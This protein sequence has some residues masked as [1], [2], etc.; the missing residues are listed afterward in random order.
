MVSV[1]NTEEL[2]NTWQRLKKVIS[3]DY[4]SD[5]VNDCIKEIEE[6]RYLLNRAN[7]VYGETDEIM[8][9]SKM[10]HQITVKADGKKQ[11][12]I[13]NMYSGYFNGSAGEAPAKAFTKARINPEDLNKLNPPKANNA[14]K[15]VIGSIT[16]TTTDPTNGCYQWVGGEGKEA[17]IFLFAWLFVAN[18][19]FSQSNNKNIEE[20][21]KS[22]TKN[23]VN[24]SSFD[25]IAHSEEKEYCIYPIPTQPEITFCK[26]TR[27]NPGPPYLYDK[28][29]INNKEYKIEELFYEENQFIPNKEEPTRFNYII[30]YQFDFNNIKYVCMY[31]IDAQVP[32][33]TPNFFIVLI[34]LTESD[35]R[36][37]LL[38]E[39]ASFNPLCFG[40][41]NND[42]KLDYVDWRYGNFFRPYMFFY[43]LVNHDF[44]KNK[45]YFL[46]IDYN[47][48]NNEYYINKK[49]SN[50]FKETN[51]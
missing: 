13:I 42:G 18:Q 51:E 31:L 16:G 29:K 44:E 6:N 40:D 4:E 7:W 20:I 17:F 23:P 41:F 45:K 38:S 32:T 8:F 43:S 19:L 36:P 28:L 37:V 24:F 34:N 48:K 2:K 9:K 21:Y 22:L 35:I 39:Q 47:E 49:K 50:W 25:S 11:K 30:S 33:S 15:A 3:D 27:L 10:T 12:K 26:T 14:I 1:Q 5:S 46:K